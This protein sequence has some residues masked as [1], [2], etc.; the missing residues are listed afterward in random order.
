MPAVLDGGPAELI[1]EIKDE[2]LEQAIADPV[3]RQALA[4]L[5]MRS[6][7]IVPMRVGEETLGALTFV[8]SDSGR[9]FDRP[10]LA[11]AEDLALRAATAVQNA[12]LYAA[13]RRVAHTLQASLLPDTLPH[14]PGYTLA[15]AY[16]AGELGA[17]VGRRL[18]RHRADRHRGRPPRLPR[19]CHRQAASTPPR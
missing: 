19:R 12:R 15:A 13:Q 2:L 9:R 7:M 18:L 5:R 14:I 8:T 3:Q 6:A 11:F 1:P 16:Q 10:D 17:D 4:E